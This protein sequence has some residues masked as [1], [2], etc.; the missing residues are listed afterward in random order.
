[1]LD[2]D[3]FLDLLDIEDSV[4]VLDND[5]C[6]INYNFDEDGECES[7]SFYYSPKD[8]LLILGEEYKIKM[9]DV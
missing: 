3:I 1:M 6:F 5:M 8:I 4:L 9:K 7:K 2:K